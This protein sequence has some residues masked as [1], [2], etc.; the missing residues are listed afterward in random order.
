M[1]KTCNFRNI[2]P[3]AAV[4][5]LS[6]CRLAG[7]PV[8]RTTSQRC[9]LPPAIVAAA[10]DPGGHRIVLHHSDP[11]LPAPGLAE[12]SAGRGWPGKVRALAL[13]DQRADET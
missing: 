12:A 6:R 1:P 2:W 4:E 5:A 9:P 11:V 7:D 3:L 10:D 13:I 8:E